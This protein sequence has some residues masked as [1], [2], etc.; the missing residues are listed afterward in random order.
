M[1]TDAC[2]RGPRVVRS[3]ATIRLP[4][5]RPRPSHTAKTTH[6]ERW[7]VWMATNEL[8]GIVIGSGKLTGLAEHILG[9]D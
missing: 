5:A 1:T 2:R 9:D 7:G 8:F 4:R 3:E 6:P